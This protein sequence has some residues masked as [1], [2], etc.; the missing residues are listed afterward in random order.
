MD[1]K[2]ETVFC[3]YK[4]TELGDRKYKWCFRYTEWKEENCVTFRVGRK[5]FSL[6]VIENKF[7]MRQRRKWNCE[8]P[9]S[10]HVFIFFIKMIIYS[11]YR[12]VST[13]KHSLLIMTNKKWGIY[14]AFLGV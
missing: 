12:V 2:Y 10:K 9:G 7:N 6:K 14:N 4:T 13:S 8:R 1:E 5:I 3:I 11:I